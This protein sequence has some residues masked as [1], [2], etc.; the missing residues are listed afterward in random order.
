MI[1]EELAK[2][3]RVRLGQVGQGDDKYTVVSYCGE[4]H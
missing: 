4:N 2:S 3:G 1:E